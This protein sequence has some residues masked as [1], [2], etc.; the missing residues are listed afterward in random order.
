MPLESFNSK[1]F[2]P[3]SAALFLDDDSFYHTSMPLL[4]ILISS[5]QQLKP[6]MQHLLHYPKDAATKY[7]IIGAESRKLILPGRSFD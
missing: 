4:S 5:T 6:K 3:K 1:N 2:Y 7:L